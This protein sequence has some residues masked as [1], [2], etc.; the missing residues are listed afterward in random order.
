VE[1]A[2]GFHHP[3]MVHFGILFHST[4]HRYR[5]IP[6]EINRD[7]QHIEFGKRRKN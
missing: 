2:V 4:D 6:T 5:N 7:Q 3:Y 1:E